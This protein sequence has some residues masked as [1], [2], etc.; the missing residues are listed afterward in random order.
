LI[1][2]KNYFFKLG[3]TPASALGYAGLSAHVGVVLLTSTMPLWFVYD[4]AR[5]AVGTIGL[6]TTIDASLRSKIRSDRKG[7][8]ANATSATLGIIYMILA[9]GYP[10]LALFLSFGH[11]SFRMIQILRSPSLVSDFQRL[12]KDL[13]LIP[14]PKIVPDWLF[15]FTWML[16]RFT[17]DFNPIFYFNQLFRYF[18]DP[19]PWNLNKKW[20]WTLTS[21]AIVVSGLPFTPFSNYLEHKM[22]DLLDTN[23]YLASLFMFS[24][25]VISVTLIKIVFTKVLTQKRFFKKK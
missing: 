6:I 18:I 25:F 21:F 14:I 7:A 17:N 23:P 5:I 1:S 9:M 22:V 20:Q 16:R 10:N 4:Y 13:N 12:K 15:R 3:P 19:K 24:Y 2:K 8:I 11:A